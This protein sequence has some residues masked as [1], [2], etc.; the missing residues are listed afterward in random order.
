MEGHD[1]Q[2]IGGCKSVSWLTLACTRRSLQERFFLRISWSITCCRPVQQLTD[3]LTHFPGS[4]IGEGK[5]KDF[6]RMIHLA[7]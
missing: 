3:T 4:F 1:S 6:M 2:A 7:E 5:G